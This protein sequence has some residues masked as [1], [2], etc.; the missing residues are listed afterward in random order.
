M[1]ILVTG[2][3]IVVCAIIGAI[4]VSRTPEDEHRDDVDVVE[5]HS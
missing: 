2:L 3:A 4:I 5:K 1:G